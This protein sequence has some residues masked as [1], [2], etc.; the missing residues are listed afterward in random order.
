[1]HYYNIVKPSEV[2][3]PGICYLPLERVLQNKFGGFT[4]GL[5]KKESYSYSIDYLTGV[6]S[7]PFVFRFFRDLGK[8]DKKLYFEN[9][10]KWTTGINFFSERF[11]L[12]D[13]SYITVA[14]NEPLPSESKPE[15]YFDSCDHLLASMQHHNKG[16][17]FSV[18]GD[19]LRYLGNETVSN[20]FKLLL[21]YDFKC[22][23]I[24]VCC[25]CFDP[26]N[27]YVPHIQEMLSNLYYQVGWVPG[28]VGVTTNLSRNN[29]KRYQNFDNF[30]DKDFLKNFALEVAP[31][32]YETV[33]FTWGRKDST[34][35]QFR[36][37]DKWLEIATSPR[38]KGVSEKMLA[39][40]ESNYWY[41]FEYEMH[42]QY[43]DDIFRAL[44][45]DEVN[46]PG[47]FSFC[48]EDCFFPVILGSGKTR[49]ACQMP[50]SEVWE[51]F[52]ELSSFFGADGEVCKT[53]N[54]VSL[55]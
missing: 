42:H 17:F 32:I 2:V 39:D 28:S 19:G 3:D 8:L 11:C 47:A 38:F 24:D 48:A 4:V 30:R 21:A 55:E 29:V 44:A 43:A 35:C 45:K 13:Q 54:F 22:T 40:V 7:S 52:I 12:N 50:S 34:K 15:G 18:S 23:R 16:I 53:I 41:R 10:Q 6:I 33:N 26:N 27:T 20:L 51:D 37:Y 49:Q 25:D 14:F 46:V 36:L 9:F 1:M 5:S 31:G